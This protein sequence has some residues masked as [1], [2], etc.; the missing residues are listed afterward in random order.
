MHHENG[1]QKGIHAMDTTTQQPPPPVAE[2]AQPTEQQGNPA[3]V[4]SQQTP[5]EFYAEITKRPDVRAILEE[6]ATG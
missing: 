2:A 5:Q 4:P 6:L 1:I 3:P